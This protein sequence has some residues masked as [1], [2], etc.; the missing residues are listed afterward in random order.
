MRIGRRSIYPHPE[1]IRVQRGNKYG[2][3]GYSYQEKLDGDDYTEIELEGSPFYKRMLRIYPDV[4]LLGEELLPVVYDNI[5]QQKDGL[6]YFYK[7]HKIGT[8][9]QQK[10][11]VYETITPQTHSFYKII[12]NGR[13]GYL[14]IRTMR[15]YY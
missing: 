15:E 5:E 12:K 4:Y 7:D 11:A 9:P 1:L 14:D 13:A 2:L 6:I 3:F 8:Y 10:K